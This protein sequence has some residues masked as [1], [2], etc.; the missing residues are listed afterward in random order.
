MALGGLLVWQLVTLPALRPQITSG[1]QSSLES[2]V[3]DAGEAFDGYY[4]KESLA[5]NLKLRNRIQHPD[6]GSFNPELYRG[7]FKLV[8]AEH[9]LSNAWLW[10]E[11][12]DERFVAAEYKGP[13][14][15]RSGTGISGDWR[16][17]TELC[18]FLE[19]ELQKLVQDYDSLTGF[20][21][22]YWVNSLDSNLIFV[23][24]SSFNDAALIGTPVFSSDNQELIG[25]VFNQTDPW[26]LENILMR[27]FFQTHFWLS[28]PDLKGLERKYL[29]FAVLSVPGNQ[30]VYNSVAY[31]SREFEQ[32]FPLTAINSWLSGYSIGIRFRNSSVRQVADS[33]YNR[34]FYLVIGLFILLM[35]LLV[36][37]SYASR[38]LIRLGRLRSEFV[39]NVSHEIKTPLA[40]IRLAT[41]TL[42][43]GRF[44]SPEQAGPVLDILNKETGRLGYL[45]H[46]LLDFS[47]L[48]AG[49]RKYRFETLPVMAWW[50]AALETARERIGENL[51]F[52]MP[53]EALSGVKQDPQALDQVLGI[54]LD[55]AL[56]YAPPG[57]PVRLSL[58][59]KG[60]YWEIGVRDSG[61]GIP[62]D[63]QKLIFEK[64]VRLG[65]ADEH[66]VKGYGIGLSMAKVI[67][68]DHEGTIRVESEAGKGSCFY[69]G[70]PEINLP[71]EQ[72]ET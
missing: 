46:S 12:A 14:R 70:L 27:N 26:Q 54:L 37:L 58:D 7:T 35:I 64:F 21:Q 55:N 8:A 38:R 51:T 47:A 34:N 61:I 62:K 10:V 40:A 39:A 24:N 3:R 60:K 18:N 67:M 2:I 59:K 56:K 29:Q 31:G 13:N 68:R 32:I 19:A 9:P 52:E 36:L 43:L 50:R 6:T 49:K 20:M 4:R 65:N 1:L 63:K 45:V 25:I 23:Y 44:R 11:P 69:F 30:V 72:A 5:G 57:S 22:Q 41:D 53:E 15:F 66:N 42:R 48:E 33:I 71:H 28:D 17:K 16:R